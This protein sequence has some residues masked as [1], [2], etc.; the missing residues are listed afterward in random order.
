MKK[1]RVHIIAVLLFILLPS[2]YFS[3]MFK[4]EKLQQSDIMHYQGMSKEIIDY[5]NKTGE[6]P[7]WTNSMFGGMPAY[8]INMRQPYN[9]LRYVHKF[10]NSEAFR[11]ASHVFLYL[12]GFYILL[13]LFGVDPWLGI[14]GAIAYGFSSYFFIILVPGHLTKAMALGYMPML[15]GSVY[16]TFHRNYLLGG[17]LT[18]VFLGLQLVANHLQITYYTL[19][20]LLIY[21]IFELVRNIKQHSL[22]RF[23]RAAGILVIAAILAI[24]V[25]MVNIWTILDYSPFS[26]RGPSE[27]KA[28]RGSEATKTGLDKE[29]ATSWSYGIGETMD[30]LIPNFKGGSSSQLIAKRGSET[31]DLLAKTQGGP[32]AAAQII[33]QSPYFFVQYWG[34]QPGTAG[35][36]YIGA[37]VIFLFVFGMFF[38]KGRLK[39]WLFT[40][41][42][43][44]ILLAWGKNFMPLTNF[45]LDHFPGYNK[46]RTVSMILVMAEFAIPLG[47]VLALSR[48]INGDYKKEEFMRALKYSLYI[49]GGITLLFA[50]APTLS[51]LSS[52]TDKYLTQQGAGN[53]V[54]ALKEDRAALLR[55]DAFRSLILILIAAG[56]IYLGLLRKLKR[57]YFILAIG[58]L[59]LIDLWPVN[60]RY[61]NDHNFVPKRVAK[62]AFQPNKA[63]LDIL[64]DKSLD[65]RVFDMTSSDPFANSRSAYFHHAIGGY[66]GAK[67]RRYQDLI[68]Q[69]IKKGNQ[70]VLDML[71]TK[72]LII[73]DKKTN[74]PVVVPRPTSLGN[75][76]FVQN[77]KIVENADQEMDALND[78]D[79]A[80]TVILNQKFAS[81]VQGKKFHPDSLS[82]I[83]M[84][85]Y[86]PNKLDYEYNADSDELAV[87][88]EIYY[89]KGWKAFIN[90]KQQ[91]YFRGDYVL[92]AMLVP[93]GKGKIEFIFEP[94][95]YFTGNKV[96]LASSILLVLSFIPGFIKKR[97]LGLEEDYDL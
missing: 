21:G 15:I 55:A 31:F 19:L 52:P 42:V 48:L 27:L 22:K 60:K 11:P 16:Y 95:A 10:I 49:V 13:L 44:S 90:G 51:N 97:T 88:S 57:E 63:D 36:V 12:V 26:T 41:V 64:K 78:F 72:Y 29:Y 87:F 3:P 30:L 53:I 76:W 23:F 75:A 17:S 37:V 39:W 80:K 46:F 70:A 20:I 73:R 5:R 45:F 84:T 4:G 94:S 32:Q 6:E 74:Q 24:G 1:A 35:P 65:Y 67:I 56:L 58:L 91:D 61:I 28:E 85:S 77:Y 2:I 33:N 66:H 7:L 25:N 47:A 50:I 18:A 81:N 40:V 79:P 82:Y 86:A 71:N 54:Q 59:I 14:V 62:T 43:I 93:Q 83:K 96:A 69:Q 9:I 8:L 89:P 34:D 92:R 68:D 38:I